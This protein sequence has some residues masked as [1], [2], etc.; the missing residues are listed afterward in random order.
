MIPINGKYT[1]HYR[2][3][4]EGFITY[5][6]AVGAETLVS[7]KIQVFLFV[8]INFYLYENIDQTLLNKLHG[9]IH[10]TIGARCVHNGHELFTLL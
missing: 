10:Y 5:M 7:I 2:S 4:V 6:K 9:P 8:F 1:W 3:C